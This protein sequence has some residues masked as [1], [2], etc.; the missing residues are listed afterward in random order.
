MIT[1]YTTHCPQCHVLEAKLNNYNFNYLI[2]ENIQEIIDKGFLSVP[3][4]KINNSTYLTFKEANEWIEE[5]KNIN[6]N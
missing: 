5:N 6:E 1:L 3:I 2:N 4:L